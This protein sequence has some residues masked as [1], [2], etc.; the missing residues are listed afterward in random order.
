MAGTA[1]WR[2]YWGLGARYREEALEEHGQG[3]QMI[4]LLVTLRVGAVQEVL[5]VYDGAGL[6]CPGWDCQ[7][8]QEAL[9]EVRAP[10]QGMVPGRVRP[11]E[12][13][14]RGACRFDWGCQ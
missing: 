4:Q 6:A 11:V 1:R 8:R 12:M 5:Q 7:C 10:D 3:S 14:G 9:W 2:L 13:I